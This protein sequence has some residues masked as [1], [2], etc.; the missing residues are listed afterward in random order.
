MS[1]SS[2]LW[3]TLG[4]FRS[5]RV[6]TRLA[7]C[8][9]LK[10]VVRL[11]NGQQKRDPNTITG[12]TP[13]STKWLRRQAKDPF[14]KE[15]KAQGYASRAAFKLTAI[16]DRYHI[17]RRGAAV[18]DLGAA[19]GGW[20]QVTLER[21]R[22]ASKPRPDDSV[23]GDFGHILIGVDLLPIE[24]LAGMT[25]LQMDFT[26]PSTV[27]SIK[28]LLGSRKADVVLSDMA[29]STTGNHTLDHHRVMFLSEAAFEFAK[30][31]LAPGGTLLVKIFTGG[32]EQEYRMTLQQHFQSVKFVKP[33]ASRKGSSE[34]Y[35]LA[36]GFGQKKTTPTV[37]EPN[38]QQ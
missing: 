27:A 38:V 23:P 17:L 11:V 6:L 15:A 7:I 4:R 32:E 20:S 29:P 37:A 16:D 13:S 28:Q 12:K 34:I 30:S 8:Q 5:T 22:V 14:V 35:L 21:I 19:P 18:V 36:T 24:Q 3:S 2:P 1:V 9:N 26:L 33:D 10:V 25:F 31:V